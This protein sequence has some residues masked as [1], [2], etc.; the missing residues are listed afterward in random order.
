MD[1][2][3]GFDEWWELREMFQDE[4]PAVY[5]VA[6]YFVNSFQKVAALKRGGIITVPP[7]WS[8]AR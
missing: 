7:E 4:I 6:L 2:E 5:H 8:G 3:E 1:A